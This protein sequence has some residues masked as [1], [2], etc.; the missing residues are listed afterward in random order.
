MK[1]KQ[2]I[3]PALTIIQLETQHLIADSTTHGVN[4]TLQNTTVNDAWVKRDRHSYN[5]WD[6]DDLQ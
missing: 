5:V 4:N 3:Q 6:D 2:Y 1:T